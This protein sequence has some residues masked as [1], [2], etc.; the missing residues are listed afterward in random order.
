MP[1]WRGALKI[2]C[3][4]SVVSL[5]SFPPSIEN[6]GGKHTKSRHME[7]LHSDKGMHAEVFFFFFF[8]RLRLKDGKLRGNCSK[9]T[10]NSFGKGDSGRWVYYFVETVSQTS[11]KASPA[12]LLCQALDAICVEKFSCASS[13]MQFNVESIQETTV[14]CEAGLKVNS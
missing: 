13:C 12:S 3:W 5:P 8:K 10:V 1:W 11:L 2:R 14:L 7:M 6:H 4:R 9:I